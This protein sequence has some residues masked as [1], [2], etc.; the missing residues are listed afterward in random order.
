M[1]Q[2]HDHNYNI[3]HYKEARDEKYVFIKSFCFDNNIL[4][5]AIYVYIYKYIMCTNKIYIQ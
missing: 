1:N 3:F 5:T 4:N 2:D